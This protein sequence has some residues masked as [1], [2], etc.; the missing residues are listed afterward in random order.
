[1]LPCV[2]VSVYVLGICCAYYAHMLQCCC[3]SGLHAQCGHVFSA[4][5]AYSEHVVR[6]CSVYC[7]CVAH[8]LCQCIYLGKGVGT[9][10]RNFATR[11]PT[12]V[13]DSDFKV[14]RFS[15]LTHFAS[16]SRPHFDSQCEDTATKWEA[17]WET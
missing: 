12:A 13:E 17:K 8:A 2:C 14:R 4:C 16:M 9:A 6:T 5:C 15:T 10:L 3:A 7:A 11:N 1:V